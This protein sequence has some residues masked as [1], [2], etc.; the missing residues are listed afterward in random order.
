MTPDDIRFESLK[1]HRG[2]YFVEYQPPLPNHRFSI[3]QIT[4]VDLRDAETVACAVEEEARRWLIRFPVPVMASAFSSDGSLMHL[5]EVR[6]SSHLMS[7]VEASKSPP[8][9][10]WNQVSDSELPTIALDSRHLKTVF[11]EVPSKTLR[12][13]R[14]TAAKEQATRRVGWWI[15]FLWAIGVPLL[16][17]VLEWWSDSDLLGILILGYAFFK[18]AIGALRLAGRLPKSPRQ[19]LREAEDLKMRHH[20]YHC[21]RNPEAFE[22]L[23]HENFQREAIERTHAEALELRNRA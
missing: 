20:H 21:Q 7:W 8:I 12:E 16:W 9:F 23:K 10:Q 6:I 1:E 13:I 15:V 18:A 3:L 4:V 22:H 2:W 17:A 5:D 11:A 14:D 19:T